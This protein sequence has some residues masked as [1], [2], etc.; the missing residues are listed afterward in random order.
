VPD[1]CDLQVYRDRAAAWRDRATLCRDER[2]REACMALADGYDR[3]ADLL[4][5]Q[6]E[7]LR[8]PPTP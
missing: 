8:G 1:A 2:Q 7:N 6:A 4:D 5:T 3:L